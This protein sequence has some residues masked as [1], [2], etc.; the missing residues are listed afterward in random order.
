M[1]VFV[2]ITLSFGVCVCAYCVF[3]TK[4]LMVNKNKIQPPNTPFKKKTPQQLAEAA[5]DH[6]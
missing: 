6:H 2:C 4:L 3:Q 5:P 1:C